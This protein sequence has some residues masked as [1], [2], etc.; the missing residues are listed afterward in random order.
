M[1]GPGGL[2]TEVPGG[3]EAEGGDT[4]GQ[5]QIVVDGLRHVG[6][7][8]GATGLFVNLA[9]AVGGVV[10]ADGDQVLHVEFFERIQNVAHVGGV[11]GRIRPARS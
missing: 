3:L 5:W 10:P 4:G 11:F 1:E 2:H 9:A 8:H 6:D 7:F